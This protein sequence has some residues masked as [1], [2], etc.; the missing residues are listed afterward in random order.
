ML[1]P[2]WHNAMLVTDLFSVFELWELEQETGNE[3]RK[4]TG[5]GKGIE[6]RST[7]PHGLETGTGMK[8]WKP[9]QETGNRDVNRKD[10]MKKK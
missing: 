2:H 7:M 6:S 9:K 4:Q 10:Y 8:Q 1:L 3:E 5:T